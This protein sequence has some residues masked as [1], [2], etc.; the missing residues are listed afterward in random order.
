MTAATQTLF[1][2]FFRPVS[3]LPLV[4]LRIATGVLTLAWAIFLY[5]DLDPLLTYLRAQPDQEILWWQL[6]PTLPSSGMRALCL[7]LISAS[8]LLTIGLWT[9]ISAWAVFLLSLTLQR[10]NPLAFNGGDLILRGVVQLGVALGPSGTYLSVDR[11]RKGQG[12][13]PAPSIEAWPIRFIQLHISIGY[14][15]TF[16]LKVRGN[17][18]P[19]GTALWYALNLGDLARF[20][21][22]EW[23]LIPPIGVALTWLT[24]ATEAFVGLGLWWRKTRLIALLAGLGLHLGIAVTLEIGFFSLVMVTSYLAFV[25]GPTLERILARR[26]SDSAEGPSPVGL[27]PSESIG[28]P[29]I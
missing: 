5:P 4:A 12:H 11:I 24:L 2:F 26:R 9:R 27:T 21:L 16:Y 15:L 1:R 19:D 3:V 14:L 17:S 29:T 10:Y 6:L 23:L 13:L 18:W 8:A 7:G 28:A 25:R 22:P 20:D